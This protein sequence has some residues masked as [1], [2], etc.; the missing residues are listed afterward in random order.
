MYSLMV[1]GLVGEDVFSQ[2]L[3]GMPDEFFGMHRSEQ[4]EL[5]K[6][7]L[8]KVNEGIKEPEKLSLFTEEWVRL[9]R[10]YGISQPQNC[11]N[12]T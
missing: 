7:V 8:R 10:N 9:Y 11:I 12:P 4:D 1:M 6:A 2:L 3:V 5:W